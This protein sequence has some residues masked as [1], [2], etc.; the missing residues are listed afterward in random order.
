MPRGAGASLLAVRRHPLERRPAAAVH[1]VASQRAHRR[2]ARDEAQAAARKGDAEVL[3]PAGP[4]ATRVLLEAADGVLQQGL[5]RL[6]SELEAL[7]EAVRRRGNLQTPLADLLGGTT[8]RGA[9][10][11]V[12]PVC[13]EA[14]YG[15]VATP[16]AVAHLLRG[17]C[18]AR[19]APAARL[20]AHVA[21]ALALAAAL[22]ASTPFAPVLPRAVL[23]LAQRGAGGSGATLRL[24]QCLVARRSPIRRRREQLSLACARAAAAT[25]AARAPRRPRRELAVGGRRPL[26]CL[27]NWLP[28][29]G[30]ARRSLLQRAL[31]E[32]ALAPPV[33]RNAPGAALHAAARATASA[34]G[35]PLGEGAVHGRLARHILVAARVDAH[36]AGR[37]LAAV[38]CLHVHGPR[39]PSHAALATAGAR[40]PLLPLAPSSV[41]ASRGSADVRVADA[42]LFLAQGHARLA[43]RLRRLLHVP[44]ARA[45][46]AP[47]RA[48]ASAPVSP[49]APAAVHVLAGLAGADPQLA[50]LQ[51][52]AQAAVPRVL[53][54][55]PVAA[56]LA[57]AA[58]GGTRGP[59]APL[60]D[61]AVDLCV[62]RLLVAAPGLHEAGLAGGAPKAR[63]LDHLA[64]P[65]LLAALAL[66]VAEAPLAPLGKPAVRV[67]AAL[68]ELVEGRLAG[69]APAA[70]RL[71]LARAPALATLAAGAPGAPSR[72]RAVL[73]LRRAV[74]HVADGELLQS[75]PAGLA[76]VG[77]GGADRAR[78]LTE[79][80]QAALRAGGPSAPGA[81]LARRWHAGRGAKLRLRERAP[82]RLAAIGGVLD[83]PPLPEPLAIRRLALGPGLPARELAV[84]GVPAVH[85][86]GLCL[87]QRAAAHL[88]AAGAGLPHGPCA[89]AELGAGGCTPVVPVAHVAVDRRALRRAALEFASG[90]VQLRA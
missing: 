24:G 89:L 68:L 66:L 72:H 80:A 44:G 52:A 19:S 50:E 56:A 71:N 63:V 70:G 41:H 16:G 32:L 83:D 31:A 39:S 74:A 17:L 75:S 12:L 59:V 28:R 29:R 42:H 25:G 36:W 86:A 22:V 88:A 48:G 1:P 6:P 57:H 18:L 20:P 53:H 43:A 84:L 49:I 45:L 2:E 38:V 46:A 67:S 5:V 11:P 27:R 33:R 8:S 64:V 69:L 13:P 82:A 30:I 40:G 61:N 35:P 78:A 7:Q 23:R 15:L 51:A 54:N 10:A 81:K 85:G 4:K 37:R 55:L 65:R 79:A 3:Q 73:D 34:P 58:R 14:I 21:E 62:A 60:A 47:A 26:A 90:G 9:S 87:H 77:R 76:T